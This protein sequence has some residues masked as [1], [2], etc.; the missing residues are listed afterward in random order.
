VT[1]DPAAAPTL[2][3]FFIVNCALGLRTPLQATG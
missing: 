2:A 1:G 3:I